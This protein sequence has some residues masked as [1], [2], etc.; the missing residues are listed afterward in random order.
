M[1]LS[2]LV[3]DPGHGKARRDLS[4][5]YEMHRSLARVFAIDEQQPVPRFL[6]RQEVDRGWAQPVVL[7]QS[8][9]AANWQVLEAV[10]G[11]LQTLQ[12]R[13]VPPLE[14]RRRGTF[15]R[16]RLLAN[17][18]VTRG[19]KRL[20]L[21]SEDAQ[22]EWLA[23]QGQRWGFELDMA[24]VSSSG[25]LVLPRPGRKISLQQACFEGRLKIT[26]PGLLAT[27]LEMGI[28]PG[29]AFGMGMLS[30]GPG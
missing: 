25:S 30:L 12:H 10:P 14:E 26:D 7:V 13:I 28:G 8:A 29:K 22:L 21:V 3:L 4:D 19:N 2:R 23:R 16:F 17:P 9:H 24:L 1:Q 15:C 5:P 18:T 6:W 20:G 27:A 11:Y